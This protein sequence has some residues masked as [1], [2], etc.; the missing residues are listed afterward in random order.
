MA[1]SINE[2]KKL[3]GKKQNYL[4]VIDIVKD[5]DDKRKKLLC[6]CDCGNTT[7]LYPYQFN[8]MEIKS[9]GC[10]KHK[11]SYNSTHRKSNYPLYHIWETMK[12]RCYNSKN[13]KYYMYGQ[14]G[15]EVCKEWKNNF[16]LLV[17]YTR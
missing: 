12:L 13:K 5:T 4:T 16:R 14:R 9:C 17:G 8:N 7:K 1:Y 3:I 2:L 10:I 15:I 6:V 11:P